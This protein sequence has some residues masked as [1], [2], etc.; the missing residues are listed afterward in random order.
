MQGILGHIET[1]VKSAF[2]IG[3]TAVVLTEAGLGWILGDRPPTPALMR[4]TF[5]RLGATYIKLG[6]FI[7]SAPSFFPPEYVEEFQGCL[8]KTEPLPYSVIEKVLKSE[9]GKNPDE[10]FAEIDE[11]PL[12]S[13]SIA[14]VH[15][16]RLKTGEEVVIK[17]QKPGVQD[18]LLTDLN[19][20]FVAAKV[21]E[22]LAPDMS[23]ASLSAIVEEIQKTMMEECDFINEANNIKTFDEFLRKTDNDQAVVPRVYSQASTLRVLTMERF[24]GVPLTDLESIR[25]YSKDPEMTLI[26]ALNTWMASLMLNEFFHADVHAGNLLVLTDGRIG[27]IDFGIVGRIKPDTWQA[28][29]GLMESMNSMDFQLMA[30]SMVKVGMTSKKVDTK[31]LAVDLEALYKKMNRLDPEKIMRGDIN[32]QEINNL[33]MGIVQVGEKAGIRFPRE[34]AL[35]MKQFLYFDRY[36]RILAPE[37]NMFADARVQSKMITD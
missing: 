4:R 25:K 37:L 21:L 20:L 17:V 30:D 24:H 31:N 26:T 1:G 27:F 36:I 34:F 13:A 9:L 3:Q 29:T 28:M 6:Q 23:R 10:V 16:A 8:D 2:R 12:A 5:E 35:L 14:Q 22:F 19:F 15:A 18:V 7:A 11:T 33:M 32:E